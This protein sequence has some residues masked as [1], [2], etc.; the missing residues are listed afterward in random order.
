M[1]TFTFALG[2]VLLLACQQAENGDA[3]LEDVSAGSES[4]GLADA[5]LELVDGGAFAEAVDVCQQAL[6][7]APDSTALRDALALAMEQS[8]AATDAMR[9]Q[10]D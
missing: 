6:D 5:C 7:E 3:A 4:S 8:D 1:R 10:A 2:V 9:Q